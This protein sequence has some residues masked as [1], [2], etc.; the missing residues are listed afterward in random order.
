[1]AEPDRVLHQVVVRHKMRYAAKYP[2]ASNSGHRHRD[3]AEAFLF[4]LGQLFSRPDQVLCL[5]PPQV[6]CNRKQVVT[7]LFFGSAAKLGQEPD[8]LL[9]LP[10]CWFSFRRALFNFSVSTATSARH[11]SAR[12][13]ALKPAVGGGAGFLP[14]TL[15]PEISLLSMSSFAAGCSPSR[16]SSKCSVS[17]SV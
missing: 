5:P 3:R 4:L 9:V 1:M 8:Q 2:A 13:A 12:W 7:E 10:H 6:P 17:A 14:Y 16:N 15:P 11:N